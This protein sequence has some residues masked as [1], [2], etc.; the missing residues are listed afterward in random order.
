LNFIEIVDDTTPLWV[1]RRT[2]GELS[3]CKSII[4]YFESVPNKSKGGLPFFNKSRQKVCVTKSFNFGDDNPINSSIYTFVNNSLSRYCNKYDY[5]NKLNTSSYWRLCPVYN[6]QKYEEGEGFF[7]LHNEQSGSYPY[8]L[9]AWMIYLNDA[10]SGTEFPY[11]EMIVTPKEGRTVIWPAGWTHPHKGVTP[12]E[13]TKYI[14]TG[15]FYTLPAG[16]PKF[17]GRHPDEEKITEILV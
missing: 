8:R 14:A 6:L 4:E 16:E 15:W 13:G 11:Q 10:K 2:Y 5:L 1:K 17:D 7:S 3:S 12:N 9:L